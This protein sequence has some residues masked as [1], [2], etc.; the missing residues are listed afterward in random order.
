[1][2]EQGTVFFNPIPTGAAIFF[3]TPVIFAAIWIFMAPDILGLRRLR[4]LPLTTR[5][6][7]AILTLIPMLFWVAYWIFPLAAYWMLAGQL[8]PTLRLD[9]LAGLTGLTCMASAAATQD[10]LKGP[11]QIVVLPLLAFAGFSA[12]HYYGAPLNTAVTSLIGSVGWIA[13][14]VSFVLHDRALQRNGSAYIS[15]LRFLGNRRP[16]WIVQ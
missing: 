2:L 7:A 3:A 15:R 6:V 16:R 14:A 8:P 12:L 11:A 10:W 13:V 5:T 4:T 1:M 9:L